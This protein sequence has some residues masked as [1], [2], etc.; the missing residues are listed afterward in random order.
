MRSKKAKPSEQGEIAIS[1][2]KVGHAKKH[3]GAM[4]V[5]PRKK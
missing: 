1:S 5:T 2:I 4:T 3:L